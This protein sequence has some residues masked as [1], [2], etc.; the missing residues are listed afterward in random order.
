MRTVAIAVPDDR[1]D[2][3]HAAGMSIEELYRGITTGSTAFKVELITP[4]DVSGHTGGRGVLSD[5]RM[6]L[7]EQRDAPK[8]AAQKGAGVLVMPYSA[9]PLESELPVVV[10]EAVQMGIRRGL[11]GRALHA[12]R[13][14]GA[15]GAERRIVYADHHP[16]DGGGGG[17][18]RLEPWVNPMFSALSDPEDR[19]VV[20]LFDLPFSYVLAHG[21]RKQEIPAL[22][23]AWTWVDGSVGDSVPLACIVSDRSEGQLWLSE[24]RRLGLNSVRAVE[25]VDL[26]LLPALYRRAEALLVGASGV[27][28]QSLRWALATGL[29]VTAFDL[30]VTNSV[31]GSSGYLVPAGDTRALGAACLTVI[32][33]PEVRERLKRE[34]LARARHYHLSRTA[35]LIH[36]QISAVLQL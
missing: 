1:S 33:E 15:S 24:A 25:G 11:S 32:V 20:D 31:L 12:A 5:W 8:L 9:A 4:A 23:A 6:L 29:P 7:F 17:A 16:E 36:E 10:I 2:W 18:L 28:P 13:S 35:Q 14:A 21:V 34:G 30:T 27:Q 19:G 3:T 26:D 22:L